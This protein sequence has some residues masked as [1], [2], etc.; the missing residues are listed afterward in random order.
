MNKLSKTVTWLRGFLTAIL[1]IL[2]VCPWA[3]IIMKTE[4]LTMNEAE[5]ALADARWRKQRRY[6]RQ[7]GYNIG[8]KINL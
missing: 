7:T 8:H 6:A 5:D 3:Y 4:G 2:S 1:L